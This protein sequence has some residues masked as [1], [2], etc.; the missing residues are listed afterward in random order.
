MAV[1]C[2]FV[3]VRSRIRHFT[4]KGDDTEVEVAITPWEAALGAD[5]QVP[6]LDGRAGIR[7]PPGIAPA[8]G[9]D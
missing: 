8:N 9:C 7:V 1:I 3:C 2:M 4:V 5:I 6:I